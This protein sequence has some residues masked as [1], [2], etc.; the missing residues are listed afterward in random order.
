MTLKT[1]GHFLNLSD[2]EKAR[3]RA[4]IAPYD[5]KKDDGRRDQ[6]V[7]GGINSGI[8]RRKMKTLRMEL[9]GLL[10]QT[11]SDG[12]TFQEAIGCAII[13][14]AMRGDTKAFELIRD[15][16]G[17]K[18]QDKKEVTLV[19]PDGLKV[20]LDLVKEMENDFNTETPNNG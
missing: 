4:K 11:G 10:E 18:P 3:R 16:I 12:K 19:N 8:T 5:F 2:E 14:K 13:E 17:Q 7:K 9:E 20:N 1:K 15:T 6:R